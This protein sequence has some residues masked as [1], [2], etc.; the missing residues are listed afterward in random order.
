MSKLLFHVEGVPHTSEY[1]S[2]TFCVRRRQRQEVNPTVSAKSLAAEL[3][4]L[5]KHGA[6]FA[7]QGITHV[8]R[9]GLTQVGSKRMYFV[10]SL[11]TCRSVGS[12]VM[13]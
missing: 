4:S 12:H 8:Q 3:I 10:S 5:T 6:E 2:A 9:V 7:A 1:T 11:G 13:R